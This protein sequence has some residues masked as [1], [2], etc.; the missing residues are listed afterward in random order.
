MRRSLFIPHIPVEEPVS[1]K[2]VIKKNLTRKAED[3]ESEC[4]DDKDNDYNVSS[5]DGIKIKNFITI[6]RI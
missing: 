2:N 4:N 1:V 5:D 6:D 3:L